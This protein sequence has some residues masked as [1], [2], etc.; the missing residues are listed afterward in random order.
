VLEPVDVVV[1]CRNEMPHARRTLEALAGQRASGHGGAP[2][3]PWARVLF[4]DC[5]STDGSRQAAAA[6]GVT[7]VDW[8]PGAYVPGAVLNFGMERTRSPIVAFVNA[9]AIPLHPTALAGLIEPLLPGGSVAAAYARQLSRPDADPLTRLDHARAFP[10]GPA[11]AVRRG[12]FFSMAASAIRRDVWERLPFDAGLRYSEDVDWVRRA[13]ALGW[14]AAYAPEASF[15]HSHAYDVAASFRRR[16]GEGAAD[17]QI[18]RL[19]A[20]S[21]INDFARPLA[22]SL[23]RDARAGVLSSR[24]L[25]TRVAQASG[26]LVGRRQIA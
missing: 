6:A 19:G 26:Y 4:I 12:A 10:P 21:L 23:L 11:L 16:R 13:E 15:E 17:T 9:D 8:D 7:I 1:R 20:P 25:L 3:E 2:S 14:T 24:G 18:F 22:G 5:G